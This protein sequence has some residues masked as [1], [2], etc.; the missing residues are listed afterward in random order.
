MKFFTTP[1]GPWAYH[2]VPYHKWRRGYKK[3]HKEIIVDCG[4]NSLVGKKEYPH[5]H[6]YPIIMTSR[7]AREKGMTWVVPDYPYDVGPDLTQEEC[8]K[9][10]D[11]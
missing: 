10:R 1:Y 9:K 2:L 7:E 5:I 8:I 6:E 3:P 4:V 11:Q